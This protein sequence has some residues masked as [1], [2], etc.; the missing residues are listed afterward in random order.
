MKKSITE[1]LL[2]CSSEELARTAETCRKINNVTAEEYIKERFKGNTDM[3]AY[4][5]CKK[6]IEMASM[7][8]RDRILRIIEDNEIPYYCNKLKIKITK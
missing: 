7:E 6:A 2:N 8:E 1:R 4:H 5:V 3:Y